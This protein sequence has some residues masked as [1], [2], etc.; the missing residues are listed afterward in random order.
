[1]INEEQLLCEC[2]SDTFTL[3]EKTDYEVSWLILI[4]RKCYK[5]VQYNDQ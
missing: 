2:G 4:C 5:E 3:V 1:M